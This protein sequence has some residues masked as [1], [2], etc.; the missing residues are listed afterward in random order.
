ME[1]GIY[2][3]ICFVLEVQD[4]PFLVHDKTKG[5]RLYTTGGK[6]RLNL[7]PKHRRQLEPDKTV[8]HAACLLGINEVHVYVPGIFYGGKYGR[9]CD[10]KTYYASCVLAVESESLE[11]MP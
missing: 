9:L 7:S 5:Y 6:L 3:I 1:Q 2:L 8:Q 10:L 11:K 4:L